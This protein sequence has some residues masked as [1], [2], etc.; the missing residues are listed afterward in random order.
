[1]TTSRSSLANGTVDV[2]CC[3]LSIFVLM[4]FIGG[5]APGGEVYYSTSAT[6]RSR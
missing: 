3:C 6:S 4:N 2:L 5:W 1:M